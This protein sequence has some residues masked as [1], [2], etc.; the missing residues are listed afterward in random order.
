MRLHSWAFVPGALVLD[1]FHLLCNVQQLDRKVRMASR[2]FR[3][4]TSF[5]F[6]RGV[7][8]AE[9]NDNISLIVPLGILAGVA[10]IIAGV[11][12]IR[13]GW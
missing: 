11:V 1:Y 7:D 6:R 2:R 4:L 3:W 8:E 12:L 5:H 10:F 9:N 13:S